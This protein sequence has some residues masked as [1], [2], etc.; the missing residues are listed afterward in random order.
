LGGFFVIVRIAADR[1]QGLRR[2]GDEPGDCQPARDVLDVGIE[3]AV[4]VDDDDD[5]Q[6]RGRIA[7]PDQITVD[8][9]VAMRR[10]NR[11][12]FGRNSAVP[13][14]DLQR[15]SVVR[16]EHLEQCGCCYSANGKILRAV[17]KRAATDCAMHIL[18][19]QVQ[20]PLRKIGRFLSFHFARSIR[21]WRKV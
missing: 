13:F 7:W 14:R 4:L 9:A 19:K 12:R 8:A 1:G 3:A 5:R 17:E 10:W 18:V 15:P 6:L 21:V 11:C 20:K 2:K 16:F